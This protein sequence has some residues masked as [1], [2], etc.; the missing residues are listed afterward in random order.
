MRDRGARLVLLAVLALLVLAPPAFEQTAKSAAPAQT[1]RQSAQQSDKQPKASG[2]TTLRG[3][4]HG[5]RF[6]TVDSGKIYRLRGDTSPLVN[7]NGQEVLL[8][9]RKAARNPRYPDEAVVEFIRLKKVFSRPPAK[10]NTAVSDTSHWRKH[11]NRKYGIRFAVPGIFPQQRASQVLQGSEFVVQH[12]T[13]QLA[14][15]Q[16]AP[17]AFNGAKSTSGLHPLPHTFAGGAFTIFVNPETTDPWLC[18][19]FE[20]P[21]PGNVLSSLTVRGIHYKEHSKDLDAGG[22]YYFLETFHTFQHGSCY[23]VSFELVEARTANFDLGCMI[24][25]V[26]PQQE[27]DFI[28]RILSQISFFDPNR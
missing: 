20:N 15:F 26:S 6:L 2:E 11:T 22:S 16:V 13:R 9:G 14:S 27:H 19:K 12:G 4:L 5:E 7:H 3:C 24:P 10:L 1:L 25:V 21:N 17:E 23:A 8:L 18:Q 28:L